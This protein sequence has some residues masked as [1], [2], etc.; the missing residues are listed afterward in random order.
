MKEE[1]FTAMDVLAEAKKDY[2][3]GG[4]TTYDDMKAQAV[5]VLTLRQANEK[6][7]FGRIKT[8]I[9]PVAI[10]NLLR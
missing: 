8:R 4:N 9:T 2:H 1:L 6:R 3:Q 5:A 10:S 7:L